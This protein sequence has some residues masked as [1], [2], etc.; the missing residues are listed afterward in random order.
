MPFELF[1]LPGIVCLIFGFYK[2]MKFYKD[3]D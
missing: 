3:N 2:G 1:L